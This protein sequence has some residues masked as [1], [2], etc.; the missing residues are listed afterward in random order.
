MKRRS[1]LA[2]ASAAVLSPAIADA[3]TKTAAKGAAAGANPLLAPWKGP[4]GGV[5][6]FDKVKE[7]IG[8]LATC[9]EDV[10]SYIAFP[11]EAE[12][13]LSARKEEREKKKSYTIEAIEE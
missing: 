3:A 13:F 2:A 12:K 10:L 6:A 1:F 5:P 11:R 7:E 9:D 4:F 8:D